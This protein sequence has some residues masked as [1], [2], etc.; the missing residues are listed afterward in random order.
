MQ[1]DSSGFGRFRVLFNQAANV[2]QSF[3][4]DCRMFKRLS[5]ER[6][7]GHETSPCT[8]WVGISI[9]A[10]ATLTVNVHKPATPPTI[11]SPETTAAT[12]SGV[13]V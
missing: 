12:P 13:P 9:S 2:A 8:A 4:R 5:P 10:Y 6:V 7:D 1:G 3:A 11:V